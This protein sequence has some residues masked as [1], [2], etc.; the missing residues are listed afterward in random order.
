MTAI[1]GAVIRDDF[2]RAKELEA[3]AE[4]I[5]IINDLEGDNADS[6]LMRRATS[7][8]LYVCA[9]SL[10]RLSGHKYKSD[11]QRCARRVDELR[12]LIY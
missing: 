11:A 5:D 2:A 10:Y 9:G 8:G 3:K 12:P 7:L 6:K 1:K 4:S